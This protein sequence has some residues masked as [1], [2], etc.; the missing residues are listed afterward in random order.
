MPQLAAIRSAQ[1]G[2]TELVTT[3]AAALDAGIAA[4]TVGSRLGDISHAVAGV[5][6]AAGYG[7]SGDYGGHGIG[8]RMHEDPSVS[9]TGR[10]GR[11]FRLRHG[12]VRRRAVVHVGGQ[13][14]Y[15][16]DPDGWPLRSADGSR[17]VHFEHTVAITDLGPQILTRP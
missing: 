7:I 4:A 5:G 11:G 16:V 2:D 15:R 13:D 12:V 9:N 17:T 6:R 1:P 3:T 8:R 10:P 14:G